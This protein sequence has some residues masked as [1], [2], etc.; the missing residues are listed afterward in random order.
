VCALAG[1]LLYFTVLLLGRHVAPFLISGLAAAV[2]ALAFGITGLDYRQRRF[3]DGIGWALAATLAVYSI[4]RMTFVDRRMVISAPPA[5]I[6]NEL[7]RAGI[8]SGSPLAM[9]GDPMR[10]YWA[11]LDHD[12]FV[13][14]IPVDDA[15]FYWLQSADERARLLS[16]LGRSEASIVVA[17]KVPAWADLAGWNRL[18]TTGLIYRRLK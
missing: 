18:G 9:I 1:F 6:V 17:D 14:E 12:R 10:A 15:P 5:T 16:Q 7:R 13:A 2:V 8:A 3:A 4:S 11:H